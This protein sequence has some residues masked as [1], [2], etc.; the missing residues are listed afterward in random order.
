MKK[1]YYIGLDVHK[2]TISIAYTHSSSRSE[3]KFYGS[4]GGT[5]LTTERKLRKLAKELGVKLQ[6]L[7]VC[8]EAGPTG[9]VLARHLI[10]LGVDCILCSPSKTEGLHK[11]KVKTDKIDAQKIARLFKNGDITPVHIPPATS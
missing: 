1:Q 2:N 5:N 3:P 6:D 9:F 10:G 11:G 7:K 4:C 8:Y